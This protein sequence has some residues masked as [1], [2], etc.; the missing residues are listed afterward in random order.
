[1]KT[2]NNAGIDNIAFDNECEGDSK[3]RK[4]GKAVIHFPQP[5]V[6]SPGRYM[7]TFT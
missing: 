6:S 5:P 4:T 7:M 3:K 1:M 2:D